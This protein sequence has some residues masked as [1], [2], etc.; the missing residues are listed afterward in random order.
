MTVLTE[1]TRSPGLIP[2]Y[3]LVRHVLANDA[4]DSP[5]GYLATAVA[6]VTKAISFGEKMGG[7][8]QATPRLTQSRSSALGTASIITVKIYEWC[9]GISRFVYTGTSIVAGGAGQVAQGYFDARGR[10]LFF[11]VTGLSGS[12]SCTLYLS[13]VDPNAKT[14]G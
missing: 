5:T 1:K 7:F 12:E 10:K 2:D 14:F 8:V 3:H 6:G 11:G 13:S 4:A 9:P